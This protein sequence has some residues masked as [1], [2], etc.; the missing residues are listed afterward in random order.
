MANVSFIA[1]M[2]AVSHLFLDGSIGRVQRYFV[3]ASDATALFVGDPVKAAGSADPITGLMTVTRASAGDTILGVVQ[4]VDQI[5]GVPITSTILNRIYRPAST[6][7]YLMIADDP[8]TIFETQSDSS[9]TVAL[10][11]IGANANLVAGSGSIVTGLSGYQLDSSS[12]ATT[13]TLQLRL[14][15]FKQAP[16]NTFPATN[17]KMRVLINNHFYKQTTGV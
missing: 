11:D 4:A 8:Y 9:A 7:M 5:D 13:N 16:D 1:G 12:I 3:P 17:A 14:L 6:A 10:N 15:G 2:L